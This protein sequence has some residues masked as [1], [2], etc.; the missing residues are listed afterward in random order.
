M[1]APRRI[2]LAADGYPLIGGSVAA[3]VLAALAAS[4]TGGAVSTGLV[5]L[6]VLMAVL[7]AFLVNFFRDPERATPAGTNLVI[8]PADGRV[9][10]AEASVD[11]P[12][13]L[14]GRAAKVS[15]FMSPLDVHVNR[16]PVD[17]EVTGVHYNP[18]KYFAA[19]AE[20]A[21]LDNEQNAVVLRGEAGR[22]V[23]FVQIAGFLARRI[24]C[25]VK[26]GDRCRR[27]ERVGMIKLG[28][29][30]DVFIAGDVDL[31]VKVGERVRA[32]ET[33]LGVMR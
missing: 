18:G 29:R 10:V 25:R 3:A 33:V 8:S 26:P 4:L 23:A 16:A 21:S 30:V 19:F 28:S 20:K 11:E 17:G 6:A 15:V 32:G 14:H 7:A 12:R 27:G 5:V 31:S 24:V 22:Q 2:P 13:F 9:I 1:A